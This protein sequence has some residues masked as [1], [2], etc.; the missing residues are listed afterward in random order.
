MP[1]VACGS[2]LEMLRRLCVSFGLTLSIRVNASGERFLSVVEVANITYTA[3]YSNALIQKDAQLR[4]YA[5]GINGIQ[6]NSPVGTDELGVRGDVSNNSVNIDC[7][8]TVC[9]TTR[10]EWRMLKRRRENGLGALVCELSPHMIQGLWMSLESPTGTRSSTPGTGLTYATVYSVCAIVPKQDGTAAGS[11]SY[12]HAG[13]GE[14][15]SSSPFA[16]NAVMYPSTQYPI[17]TFSEVPAMA[18]AHYYFSPQVTGDIGI[19]RKRGRELTFVLNSVLQA[20]IYPGSTI[21]LTINS[22][23]KV[24]RVVRARENYLDNQTEITAELYE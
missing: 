2:L 8:F 9:N 10:A 12:I 13:N 11:G 19:Y 16:I 18:L 6:V 17:N 3:S 7:L 4:P 15:Q 20:N 22:E 21:T 14:Y 24:W 1:F 23:S 5:R